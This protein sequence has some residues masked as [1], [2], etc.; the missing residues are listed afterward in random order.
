MTVKEKR[1]ADFQVNDW[2][3]FEKTFQAEDFQKFAE[4]SG[5]YNPLHSSQEFAGKSSFGQKIVPLHMT[6]APMSMIAGMVFPGDSSLYHGH[7]VIASSP[8]FFDEKITYSAKILSLSPA[9]R[10]LEI[11]VIAWSEER[12]Q[13]VLKAKMRVQSLQAGWVPFGQERHYHRGCD[14]MALITGTSGEIGYAVA[15]AFLNRG[16][17]LA[18]NY[19]TPSKRIELLKAEG[20]EK[21]RQIVELQGDLLEESD[22]NRVVKALGGEESLCAIVHCASATVDSDLAQQCEINFTALR[23]LFEGTLNAFLKKQKGHVI[24]I[25]SSAMTK[26]PMGWENYA[27]AKSMTVNYLSN[28]DRKYSEF[29]VKCVTIAPGFVQTAFSEKYRSDDDYALLPEE[30]AETVVAVID[31][32]TYAGYIV[33]ETSKPKQMYFGK[34][35]AKANEHQPLTSAVQEVVGTNEVNVSTGSAVDISKLNSVFRSTLGL[36]NEVDLSKAEIGETQGWDSLKHLELILH[37]ENV[38]N[39]VFESSE[40]A[41]MHTYSSLMQCVLKKLQ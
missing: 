16:W 15:R 12:N 36:D 13:I 37:L 9:N 7:E 35:E 4:I 40:I 25:G 27:A 8:V 23:Q 5:D 17:D 11:S 22:R 1:F 26:T 21:N 14:K 19:R 41:T 18:I 20:T 39:V 33:Y 10:I 32:S 28:Q 2:F 38:F 30:V 24:Y 3:T 6:C 29:G 31:D 34:Y